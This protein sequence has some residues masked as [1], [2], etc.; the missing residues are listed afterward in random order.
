MIDPSNVGP[1]VLMPMQFGLYNWSPNQIPMAPARPNPA[2][3][4]Y[5][6]LLASSIA[7]NITANR[8]QNQLRAFL[9]NLCSSEQW[10]GRYTTGLLEFASIVLLIQWMETRQDPNY[11]VQTVTDDAIALYV[12]SLAFQDF[13]QFL[14]SYLDPQLLNIC[15]NNLGH[16]NEFLAKYRA[17]AAQANQAQGYPQ[18][19]QQQLQPPYPMTNQQPNYN[20]GRGV[21]NGWQQRGYLPTNSGG[22]MSAAMFERYNNSAVVTPEPEIATLQSR[23]TQQAKI[24]E[25]P[26]GITGEEPMP[27]DTEEEWKPS[28]KQPYRHAIDT[29]FFFVK[30]RVFDGVVMEYVEVKVGEEEMD[31]SQHLV[32]AVNGH[33]DYPVSR[34]S[35]F[36]TDVEALADVT[37]DSILTAAEAQDDD[38]PEVQAV[39]KELQAIVSS[40]VYANTNIPA[41]I[42]AGRVEQLIHSPKGVDSLYRVF[43]TIYRPFFGTRKFDE[44]ITELG[45]SLNLSTVVTKMERLASAAKVQ[46]DT[47]LVIFLENV[48][49]YL[50]EIF[51]DFLTAKMG[52]KATITDFVSDFSDTVKYLENKGPVYSNGFF[53]FE[54]EL[55]KQIFQPAETDVAEMLVEQLLDEDLKTPPELTFLVDGASITYA[56]L[57]LAEFSIE[58][59]DERPKM[60]QELLT[61]ELWKLAQSAFTQKAAYNAIREH[62]LVTRDGRTFKLHKGYVGLDNEERYLI[63]RA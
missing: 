25:L 63:T 17:Y 48:N 32:G 8:G 13:N 53:R 16:F 18:P 59:E 60:I 14:P 1:E 5:Y 28:E 42:E 39:V 24:P 9:F 61:P 33:F 50:T 12:S 55:L 26:E 41:A 62:Y 34:Q 44:V 38:R 58:L 45:S 40:H 31:R 21:P 46:E 19:M 35:Q 47:E 11:L 56:T 57:T 22:Q 23:Y 20:L 37:P 2:I 49:T 54:A 10:Q 7:N 52:L 30:N 15:Q 51:N 43:T 6:P 4:Q 36:G 29:R 27:E 3:A